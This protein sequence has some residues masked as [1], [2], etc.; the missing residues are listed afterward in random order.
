MV[1]LDSLPGGESAMQMYATNVR[2]ILTKYLTPKGRDFSGVDLHVQDVPRQEDNDN[3]SCGVYVIWYIFAILLGNKRFTSCP[4]TVQ[5]I[6]DF[7]QKLLRL[8][9]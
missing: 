1:F 2:G 5:G 7:R 3:S 9:T 6:H 8:S 4:D